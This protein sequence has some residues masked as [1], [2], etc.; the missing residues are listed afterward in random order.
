MKPRL[1]PV[2][3][4]VLVFLMTAAVGPS[5]SMQ[6]EVIQLDVF[7]GWFSGIDG[8]AFNAAA[9]AF[10]AAHPDIEV[11]NPWDSFECPS[12]ELHIRVE[13]GNPPDSFQSHMGRELIENWVMPGY[14]APLDDIYA[15]SGLGKTLPK[16]ISSY[17]TY[18]DHPW[19]VPVNIHRSN[20]IWYN[21]EIF[22]AYDIKASDLK[23]FDRWE[24]AAQKLE[25]AGIVPLA[26]G[27]VD[28]W[29]DGQLFETILAGSMSAHKY[30]GLWTGET[31][32][33]D[34][35]VTKALINFK[36]MRQYVNEDHAMLNWKEAVQLMIDGNAAMTITG[37]WANG[38]FLDQGFTGF[39]WTETPGSKGIYV[40]L[41]DTF[42]LPQYS[43]H[44][45]AASEF[46]SFLASKQ[47]QEV[48][49]Q[50]KGSICARTDCSHSYYN[51]Y[52]RSAD[53]DVKKDKIVPSI[54][55]GAAA[56]DA[57]LGAYFEAIAN[58]VNTGDVAAAQAE[59]ANACIVAGVCH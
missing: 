10:H 48:I 15:E 24:A 25:A 29:T 38:E 39:G 56:N 8:E 37:D 44:P 3:F 53:K 47:A 14:V 11:Y 42:T 59:L 26:L 34:P 6:A 31:D 5:P 22:D 21:Q 27:D 54:I 7:S 18:D 46:L 19:S 58:F 32:W 1:L 23:T 12:C 43:P 30:E 49:N 40:A 4:A 45:E 51:D 33:N 13:S 57:W 9:D 50:V 55:A 41:S 20:L 17:L 16:D 52:Q 35:K 2:L 28:T 36:M